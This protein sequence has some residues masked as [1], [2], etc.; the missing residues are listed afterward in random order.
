M[1]N[2]AA[3]LNR[4]AEA[5]CAGLAKDRTP[6][7]LAFV[8]DSQGWVSKEKA[9][10]LAARVAELE[11]AAYGDAKLRLIGPVEQIRHLHACVAAQMARAETL[12]RLLREHPAAAPEV[13]A[14]H[15]SSGAVV[16]TPG[17]PED[18]SRQVSDLRGLL[19]R[20]RA[21]VEEPHDDPVGLHHDYRT[22]RDLPEIG[23]AR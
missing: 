13:E 4:L 1:N 17:R 7:G 6:M 11:A 14:L 2:T 5:L 16:E 8:V 23:G 12:D 22:P 15:A 19:A 21:A 10:A 18:V 9:D 20:Q 3:S